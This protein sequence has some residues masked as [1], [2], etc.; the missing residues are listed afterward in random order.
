MKDLIIIFV[1]VLILLLLIS[2]FG[3]S[4]KYNDYKQ[5]PTSEEVKKEHFD[6]SMFPLN[7]MNPVGMVNPHR[8]DTK[9]D[10]KKE[11]KKE[12][13]ETP[14]GVIAPYDKSE[15]FASI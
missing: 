9:A 12:S 11:V 2:T 5:K 10:T 1:V 14:V 8:N 7:V 15:I 3:G 6:G 13:F 4:I